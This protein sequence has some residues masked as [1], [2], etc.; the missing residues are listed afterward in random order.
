[1]NLGVYGADL[2]YAGTYEMNQEI[3][4]YLQVS[5]QLIEELN[6]STSFNRGFVERVE[7]N[8]EDKDS[9]INIVSESFNDTY[10]FLPGITGM[11]LLF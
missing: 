3:M 11:T 10:V 6:I 2:S 8:L 7:R 5:K 9:L 4:K 1:L